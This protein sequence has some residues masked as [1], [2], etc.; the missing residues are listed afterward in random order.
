MTGGDRLFCVYCRGFYSPP[1]RCEGRGKGSARR[2]INAPPRGG[3]ESSERQRHR[4]ERAAI[5]LLALI[6]ECLDPGGFTLAEIR[7]EEDARLA[8][9]EDHDD[10]RPPRRYGPSHLARLVK[11]GAVQ[12]LGGG[13]YA[14]VHAPGAEGLAAL[15]ELS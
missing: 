5:E 6:R 3:F 2:W 10:G 15:W 13:R 12:D 7:T 14:V 9:R 11:S 1:H 4:H 8:A